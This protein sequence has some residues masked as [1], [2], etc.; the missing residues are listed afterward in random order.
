[1]PKGEFTQLFVEPGSRRLGRKS[2]SGLKWLEVAT[3]TINVYIGR[4][5]AKH[6]SFCGCMAKCK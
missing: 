2:A 5:Q 6:D 4:F 1:M 3:P